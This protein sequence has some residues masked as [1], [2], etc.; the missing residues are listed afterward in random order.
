MCWLNVPDMAAATQHIV[1]YHVEPRWR[2][3]PAPG[4]S[5]PGAHGRLI[6]GFIATDASVVRVLGEARAGATLGLLLYETPLHP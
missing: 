5:A 1:A 6:A 4:P 3:G 2:P